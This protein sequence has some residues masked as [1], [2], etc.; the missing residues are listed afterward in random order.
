MPGE[1]AAAGPAHEDL[2]NDSIVIDLTCPALRERPD[3]IGDWYAAGVTVVAPTIA[4]NHDPQS[5]LLTMA[6]WLRILRDDE[7]LWHVRTVA[8]IYTAKAERRLGIMFAFQNTQPIATSSELLYAYHQLGLRMLQL[9]Y[10]RQNYV[11]SGCE[12]PHDA[13]L[14]RFGRAV[15]SVCNKLGVVVDCAHTGKRTTL[16]AVEASTA[17]VVVS[18]ANAYGVHPS[19]RNVDDDVIR[20]VAD[21]GGVIGLNCFP[22]FISSSPRPTVAELVRHAA[23]IADLVG[24]QHVALGLDYFHLASAYGSPAAAS[25][26]YSA[27]VADGV[28]HP[29]QYPPPPWHYPQGM[30]TVRGLPT[31]VR[32]LA[33]AGFEPGDIRGVLGENALR[34]FEAVWKAEPVETGR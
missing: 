31:L 23:Y 20:A 21:S 7:R 19:L 9:A 25:A 24:P 2:Y 13:G 16:D 17:P 29:D 22:A 5:T 33:R 26:F 14:S 11:G 28:W 34:V 10:N 8:D 30:E 4:A 18:H 32:E 27:A 15:V 12:E 6:R 1:P 3:L